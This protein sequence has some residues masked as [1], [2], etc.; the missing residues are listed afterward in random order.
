[1]GSLR[2]FLVVASILVAAVAAASAAGSR[3]DGRS[4]ATLRAGGDHYLD[5]K[6]N[7]MSAEARKA[8]DDLRLKR[9]ARA[10]GELGDVYKTAVMCK[11]E[12]DGYLASGTG[13]NAIKL[14]AEFGPSDA[15][16]S[17]SKISTSVGLTENYVL[18]ASTLI[19]KIPKSPRT[20]WPKLI[21]RAKAPLSKAF[22]GFAQL[23]SQIAAAEATQDLAWQFEVTP[24]PQ[25]GPNFSNV[26]IHGGSK[27]IVG[28]YL[29]D[30]DTV[31][32]VSPAGVINPDNTFTTAD[33]TIRGSHFVYF[34]VTVKADGTIVF[35]ISPLVRAGT[36]VIDVESD[37]QGPGP[38]GFAT[39]RY[40]WR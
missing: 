21:K 8:F 40:F 7:G 32:D 15:S 16:D 2:A 11:E 9:F 31:T 6:R 22:A 14:A 26:T 30:A 38:S 27:N 4:P 23:G 35:S 34:N 1:M 5:D 29:F 24:S 10:K 33:P 18:S 17:L 28:V 13:P 20:I 37:A 25:F 36:V 39:Q 19:A 12:V 3:S